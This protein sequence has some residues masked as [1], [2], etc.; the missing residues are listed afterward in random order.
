MNQ[1]SFFLVTFQTLSVFIPND[2]YLREIFGPVYPLKYNTTICFAY[3]VNDCGYEHHLLEKIRL[4]MLKEYE[5]FTPLSKQSGFIE[6][7]R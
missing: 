7:K 3:L 5:Y 4:G 1:D 6:T 2:E